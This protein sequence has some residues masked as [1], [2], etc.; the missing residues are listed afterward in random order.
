M[1]AN[2]ATEATEVVTT[3]GPRDRTGAEEQ[4]RLHEHRMYRIEDGGGDSAGF[5]DFFRTVF[6]QAQGGADPFGGAGPFGGALRR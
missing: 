3:A 2:D 5:S 6:G 1:V 4:A